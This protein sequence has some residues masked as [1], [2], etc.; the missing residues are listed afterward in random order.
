M[1]WSPALETARPLKKTQLKKLD[2]IIRTDLA[3]FEEAL[4]GYNIS[5]L[6][7]PKA[8]R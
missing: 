8:R 6:L 5:V 4:K 7:V 3:A 2:R 1:A